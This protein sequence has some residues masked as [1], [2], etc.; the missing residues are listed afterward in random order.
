[1]KEDEIGMLW[2]TFKFSSDMILFTNISL[3]VSS[4][5]SSSSIVDECESEGGP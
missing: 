5:S 2:S 4:S 1:M 3:S